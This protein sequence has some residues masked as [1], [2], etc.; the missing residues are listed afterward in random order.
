MEKIQKESLD[1]V[2]ILRGMWR[3]H[4]LFIL[5]IFL[6]LAAPL[7]AVM[8][9]TSEPLYLSTAT[10]AIESSTMEKVPIFRDWPRKDSIAIDLV[11]LNSRSL[12]EGVADA[13][14]KESFEELV[15]HSQYTDYVIALTNTVKQWMGKQPTVFSPRQRAV[16]ELQKARM[17][18]IQSPPGI[19]MIKGTASSARVAMDLV[20][21]Y[22]QLLL[23]RTRSSDQ[24][25]TR[26]A[27]E[28]LEEQVQQ[29]KDNLT[30]A[31]QAMTK[32]EQQKGRIML[33]T[34][35]DFDLAKLSETES[36]L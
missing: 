28:F 33:R 22:I 16:V 14:P 34:Q 7:L 35:T 12:S 6:A 2:A 27:R 25:E 31:E 36:A 19:F 15:N 3:R 23:S 18:F 32:Y 8:Y 20:N 17:Q 10:I 24:E 21:T 9:V 1:H 26:K 5:L 30:Q 29:A 13:L 4:K 11:L